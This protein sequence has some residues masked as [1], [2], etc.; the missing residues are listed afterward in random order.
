LA[1][2]VVGIVVA[3][4][5]GLSW[6]VRDGSRTPN[7]SGETIALEEPVSWEGG[8]LDRDRLTLYFIG[9]RPAQ[10]GDPCSRAYK[11][12]VEPTNDAMVVSVRAVAGP[13]LLPGHG[14]TS[15]GYERSVTVDLP[16][17]L[18]GRPIVDGASGQRR[19]ISD[20]ALLLRP[21]WLPAGYHP[22]GEH[23]HLDVDTQEWTLEGHP[24]ERLLVEQG[25]VDKVAR[26]GFDPVVLDRPT[27]RG[28]P[29]TVWKTRGF[30][31]LVCVSWAEGSEGH[32]VC[33]SGTLGQLLPHDVL[34]RVAGEL[35]DA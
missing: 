21:S 3:A 33:S 10:A 15:E 20:V 27:V 2:L 22:S 1:F 29:A 23:V 30:D 32:R 34:V 9:A 11:A 35:R 25:D 5:V 16:A 26:P 7:A 31:D 17:P 18:Q 24:D 6:I 13:P 4:G 12:V 28:V 14:C 8:R 19:S